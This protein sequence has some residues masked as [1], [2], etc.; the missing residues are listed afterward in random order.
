MTVCIPQASKTPRALNHYNCSSGLVRGVLIICSAPC[1]N[2][3][4]FLELNK[5]G[6]MSTVL[7]DVR[8]T[9]FKAHV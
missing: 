1:E 3:C 9:L 7:T 6:T 8:S 4:S 2:C 5:K